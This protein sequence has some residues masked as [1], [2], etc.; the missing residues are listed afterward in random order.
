MISPALEADAARQQF[1][2]GRWGLKATAIAPTVYFR[3][4]SGNVRKGASFSFSPPLAVPPPPTQQ[5]R[6]ESV[7][8][9]RVSD[10]SGKKV[11]YPSE[12]KKGASRVQRKGASDKKN[13]LEERCRRAANEPIDKTD[14]TTTE[15][16]HETDNKSGHQR[17][18]P[19]WG[20]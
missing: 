6:G 2:K 20:K 16:A 7:S 10:K 15:E 11:R 14:Q 9:T 12:M 8:E 1:V 17:P 4:G 5:N 19:T 18:T 3:M 13:T